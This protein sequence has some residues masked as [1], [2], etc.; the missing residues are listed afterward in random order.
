MIKKTIQQALAQLR[1]SPLISAINVVG[2][3]LAIFLIML[4]VMMQQVKTAPFSP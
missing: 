3:A 4:V 1:Q 2:T